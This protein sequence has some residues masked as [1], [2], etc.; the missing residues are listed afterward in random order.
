MNT[1]VFDIDL[2]ILS[3]DQRCIFSGTSGDCSQLA[4]REAGRRKWRA[5][6]RG[7]W[8]GV[9]WSFHKFYFVGWNKRVSWLMKHHAVTADGRVK[10][11]C[12]VGTGEWVVSLIPLPL[13]TCTRWVRMRN[14]CRARRSAWRRAKYLYGCRE[15]NQGSLVIHS[16]CL[17][18][19]PTDLAAVS[20]L[21]ADYFEIV[22]D[23][24]TGWSKRLCVP[25][26]GQKV[27]VHLTI[28]V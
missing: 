27:S 22:V 19:M 17:V 10:T 28:T 23:Y 14:G 24:Y 25:D 16:C 18:V 4:F 12:T 6:V 11:F 20:N 13:D 21:L 3:E 5:V 1:S 15:S 9:C 8:N 2:D 7:L 26:D